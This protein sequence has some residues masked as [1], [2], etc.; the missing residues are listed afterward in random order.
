VFSFAKLTEVDV[1][2]G[3]EMKST[4]E[5]MGV[6]PDY[7]RALY[8]AMVAS[9]VSVPPKGSLIATIADRDKDEAL[10]IIRQ[11]ADMGYRIYA[12]TGTARFLR[13]NG[14]DAIRV[15]KIHEGSPNIL[16]L[17]QN[18]KIDLL[19]NTISNDRGPAREGARIRRTSVEH[20]IPCLTSLD[21]TRALLVALSAQKGDGMQVRP[22]QS[23]ARK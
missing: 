3:P 19:I 22:L 6:D 11:F 10:P 15:K 20:A 7:S 8:K 16:D 2:L 4:G 17:V 21:T 13:A 1:A 14:V 18:E 23:Y 9:G 5:I 12:T